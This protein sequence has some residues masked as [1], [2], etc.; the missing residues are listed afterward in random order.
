MQDRGT[1]SKKCLIKHVI[2]LP[3]TLK[4]TH[5]VPRVLRCPCCNSSIALSS[6]S[7]TGYSALRWWPWRLVLEIASIVAWWNASV[8]E[9]LDVDVDVDCVTVLVDNV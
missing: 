6:Y 5:K 7:R 3:T 9:A 8:D 4:S 2:P 1:K